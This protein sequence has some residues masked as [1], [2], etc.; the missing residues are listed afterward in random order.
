[1]H[2]LGKTHPEVISSPMSLYTNCHVV[3]KLLGSM[4]EC[5]S[6][7]EGKHKMGDK[8]AKDVNTFEGHVGTHETLEH[9]FP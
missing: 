1:M 4:D 8:V 2:D 9:R 3:S 6:G 5:P 7:F